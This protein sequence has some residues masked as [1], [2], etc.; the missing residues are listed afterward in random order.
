MLL[1]AQ[2]KIQYDAMVLFPGYNEYGAKTHSEINSLE[3]VYKLGITNP[4][5][6][7]RI[8]SSRFKKV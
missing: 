2:T 7:E 1:N 5:P 8:S 6:L 4:T 3:I